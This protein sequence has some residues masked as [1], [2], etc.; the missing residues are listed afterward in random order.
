MKKVMFFITA[1]VAVLFCSGCG[2]KPAGQGS[3]TTAGNS[4]SSGAGA[5]VW[6]P[7]ASSEYTDQIKAVIKAK[8][9]TTIKIGFTNPYMSEYY[10]EIYMG[11]YAKMR[12]LEDQFG[13]K[14]EYVASSGATHADA[15]SQISALRTWGRQG[16]HAVVVCTAA[17]P[18]AMDAVF[19]ELL[20]M[21]TYPYFFN[22]PPRVLALNPDSPLD[23]ATM[24]ARAIVGYDNFLAHY[25]AGFWIADLLTMKYGSPKGTI[26]QVWGPG[27]HWSAERGAGFEAAMKNF[28]NIRVVPLVRG[29]YDRDSGM[30]GAEDLMTL[31]P[32]LDVIYGENE[33]MGL[34]AAAAVLAQGKKLWDFDKKEGI[35]TVG[36]DGLVSGYNEIRAGRMT[37]TIDVNPVENGGKLIEAIFWDRV[38]GWRIPKIILAPT[39]V[40]DIRNVDTHESYVK[41]AQSVTYP[42]GGYK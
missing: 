30:K 36:A 9:L 18:T 34:G 5:P 39:Q 7:G 38:L 33:E 12:E 26:G 16:F 17:E 27:G 28:P 20:G 13:I 10:N 11:A 24:N 35:I 32:N 15:E 31:Y 19:G 42:S 8:G 1:F 37:A 22:M 23:D 40:V 29:N 21:G 2:G 3:S 14:F 41:W 4:V 6:S 25:D